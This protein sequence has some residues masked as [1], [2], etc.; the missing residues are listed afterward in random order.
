MFSGYRTRLIVFSILA[1]APVFGMR[2]WEIWQEREAAITA[3]QEHVVLLARQAATRQADLIADTRSLLNIVK[4]VPVLRQ[5]DGPDCDA[6]ITSFRDA[7]PWIESMGVTDASG[8]VRCA[9]N[10]EAIGVNLSDREYLKR[11][12]ASN[13][14][15][16][17]D[18]V[19]NRVTKR[20]S[21]VTALPFKGTDGSTLVFL[22]T[23]KLSWLEDLAARV[24]ADL[25]GDIYIVDK[26]G[27][28]IASNIRYGVAELPSY[29]GKTLNSLAEL[30]NGVAEYRPDGKNGMV[31]GYAPIPETS[32][33]I[34]IGTPFS[35]ILD[36][37]HRQTRNA[38]RDLA[39]AFSL[40]IV[41]GW[42]GGEILF[43]RPMRMLDQ[44]ARKIAE[45]DY[46]TRAEEKHG[47]AELRRLGKTFNLMVNRLESL[48]DI[49][50]MTGLANRRQ[51]DRF[52]RERWRGEPTKSVG[53]AMVDV[54]HFKHY[55]D[56]YGHLRGDKT[57]Q[58]IAN[59]VKAF[60]FGADDLAARFGGEEFTLV[61]PDMT[62]A[63]MV[64]HCEKLRAAVER[65][66]IP[67]P[68]SAGGVVTISIGVATVIPMRCVEVEKAI[69]M[70]DEALYAAK[71]S[72][73]N[74]VIA[75][76]DDANVRPFGSARSA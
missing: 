50:P 28:V 62:R 53:I 23:L 74:R 52:L 1:V 21:V 17:S 58:A 30:S 8:T 37:V 56:F 54:D 14:F 2:F 47:P 33:R 76:E 24:A 29:S 61:I 7:R 45:G 32:A 36:S 43:L 40:I 48:G 66:G 57:L 68:E 3:T 31:F 4:S 26:S 6:A 25:N 44:T 42:I 41:I 75:H 71:K 10:P 12:L 35:S 72:G 59:I 55:N 65:L 69:R 13:S 34:F 20:P 46:G 38:L 73:R 51:L 63:A 5:I 70:A 60:G 18:L 19:L 64:E 27:S 67:R 11:A 22:A 39:L 15:V 16:V 9:A 49:D